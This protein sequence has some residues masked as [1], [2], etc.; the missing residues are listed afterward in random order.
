MS[1]SKKR[2][3]EEAADATSQSKKKRRRKNKQHAEEDD[4]IDLAAGVNTAIALM[5]TQLLADYLAQRTSRFGADLSPIE[6]SDLAL[7]GECNSRAVSVSGLSLANA[8]VVEKE[9]LI[10]EPRHPGNPVF[11][12]GVCF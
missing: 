6:L 8:P 11:C 3:A 1:N 7:P 10:T 9:I 12:I 5:D 4:L 2:T